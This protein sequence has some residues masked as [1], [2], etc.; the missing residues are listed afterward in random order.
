MKSRE[1]EQ[2]KQPEVE[3]DL[4]EEKDKSWERDQCEI[5]YRRTI[6]GS[7]YV[8]DGEPSRLSGKLEIK[9]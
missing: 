4:R 9:D 2:N 1:N 7:E 3:S 6:I 8:I 5:E